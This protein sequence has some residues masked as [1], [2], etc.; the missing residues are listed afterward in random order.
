M[1]CIQHSL[2][3][4]RHAAANWKELEVVAHIYSLYRSSHNDLASNF[5]HV[6]SSKFTCYC[7]QVRSAARA[8][9]AHR[10]GKPRRL[11]LHAHAK[12]SQHFMRL[13]QQF[14]STHLAALIVI[15]LATYTAEQLSG[16]QSDILGALTPGVGCNCTCTSVPNTPLDTTA[17]VASGPHCTAPDARLLSVWNAA[18]S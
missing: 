16:R 13:S 14:S 10:R 3:L 1:L 5:I 17:A 8:P 4:R 6:P 18:Y 11:H 7:S 2:P 15:G 12:V 9:R